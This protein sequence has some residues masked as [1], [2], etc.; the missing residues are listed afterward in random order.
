MTNKPQDKTEGSAQPDVKPT[1]RRFVPLDEYGRQGVLEPRGST[2]VE[3][4]TETT[5]YPSPWAAAVRANASYGLCSTYPSVLV[6]PRSV[7]GD[8]DDESAPFLRRV[9]AFRSEN[10]FATLTWG[11][12]TH[13]GSV[14][15]SAQ[16]KVGL[17]GNRSPEDE[18]YL[19][20]IGEEAKRANLAADARAEG[21]VGGGGSSGRPPVEF[22]RMICGRINESDLIPGLDGPGGGGGGANGGAGSAC[23]L[24]IM[25]MRPKSAAMG[26]KTQGYGYENTNNYRGSTINFYGIGN[27]HAVRDAYQ[28]VS[29]LCT[30]PASSDLQWTQLVEN[31]GWPGMI[32]LILSAAWQVAF[33]VHYNRLP[34]LVHCSVSVLFWFLRVAS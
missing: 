17:Q 21:G 2:P 30:S 22:L 28:K 3:G 27:I 26:N 8:G 5:S 15:R 6:V 33:H 11:S 10:R 4:T 16:P 29:G 1:R 9:A 13:G 12:R 14:W 18:R 25:D 32:R 7:V 34:V 24:K 19:Y 31:T 23:M 20:A